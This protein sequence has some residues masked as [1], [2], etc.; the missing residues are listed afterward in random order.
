MSIPKAKLTRRVIRI[1]PV[2]D[3]LGRADV[4]S[5][6]RHPVV[7]E[8]A[9]VFQVACRPPEIIVV[10]VLVVAE[11]SRLLKNHQYNTK[12]KFKIFRDLTFL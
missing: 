5:A 1:Q 2:V 9:H 10:V 6:A 4:V 8:N 11:P 3:D 12:M 7:V